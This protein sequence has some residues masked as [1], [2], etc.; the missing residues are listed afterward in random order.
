M[1]V[2]QW[3]LA[4]VRPRGQVGIEH[5]LLSSWVNYARCLLVTIDIYPSPVR[6][7]WRLLLAINNRYRTEHCT[8]LNRR[9]LSAKIN[10]I[11]RRATLLYGSHLGI[12]RD[13]PFVPLAVLANTVSLTLPSLIVLHSHDAVQLVVNN[14]LPCSQILAES[15]SRL[16]ALI[17]RNLPD[18]GC[19]TSVMCLSTTDM[20][21]LHLVPSPTPRRGCIFDWSIWH[22]TPCSISEIM[23]Q[24]SSF[25][26]SNFLLVSDSTDSEPSPSVCSILSLR[27]SHYVVLV[28]SSHHILGVF[29][30]VWW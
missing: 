1:H 23:V 7:R 9:P 14:F 12:I 24:A 11:A 17:R 18:C 21:Y 8:I 15:P 3:T 27:S 4:S 2:A 20:R 28:E 5:L 30:C 22:G 19:S 25:L 26:I 6:L 10:N 13:S 16:E 29:H